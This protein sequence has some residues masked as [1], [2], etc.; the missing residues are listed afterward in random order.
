[1]T[2]LE[3]LRNSHYTKPAQLLINLLKESHNIVNA[4]MTERTCL[5]IDFI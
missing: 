3:N 1:M 2:G 4:M 5:L